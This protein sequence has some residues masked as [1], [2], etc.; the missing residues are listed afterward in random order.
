MK[1]I[2]DEGVPLG[3]TRLLSQHGHDAVHVIEIGLQGAS[4]QT[5]LEWAKVNHACVIAFDSDFHQILSEQSAQ[6]PSVIRVR[7]TDLAIEQLNQLLLEALATA[8]HELTHGCMVS[9]TSKMLR[10]RT[11]P[12]I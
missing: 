6:G 7:E 10:I 12:L 11:L 2:L 1:L 9:L 5:I 8:K 4:D 3:L